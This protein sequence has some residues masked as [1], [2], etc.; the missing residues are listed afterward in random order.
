MSPN[1]CECGSEIRYATHAGEWCHTD[2]FGFVEP[3]HGCTPTPTDPNNATREI[4]MRN[5]Q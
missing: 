3:D 5:P 4:E 2:C 1:Y